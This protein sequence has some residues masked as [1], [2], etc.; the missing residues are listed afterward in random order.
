MANAPAGGTA[1]PGVPSRPEPAGVQQ[2]RAQMR[3]LDQAI[4]SKKQE[5]GS[6]QGQL[7]AYQERISSSPMVQ[8]QLKNLTRDYQTAQTFYDELLTKM[9]QSKMA[10]DLERRQEGENFKVMD[11]PNLADSPTFPKRGVFLAGGLAA[12]LALG[13]LVVAWIEYRDTALRSER[14]IWSFTKLPTLAVIS[15]STA[16]GMQSPTRGRKGFGR[17]KEEPSAAE[18]PLMSTGA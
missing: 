16:G 17:R 11:E 14:D 13:L 1:S 12:G 6:I 18:K 10:V 8:E 15:Y 3:A 4:V 5:Q 2:L 9:N 7:R